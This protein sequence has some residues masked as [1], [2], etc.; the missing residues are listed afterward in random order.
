MSHSG[1]GSP[2]YEDDKRS[3]AELRTPEPEDVQATTSGAG[4]SRLRETGH[5]GYSDGHQQ[6]PYGYSAMAGTGEQVPQP[7]S[8]YRRRPSRPAIGDEYGDD[9][10]RQ[11]PAEA[12]SWEGREGAFYNEAEAP[13]RTDMQDERGQRYHSAAHHPQPYRQQMPGSAPSAQLRDDYDQAPYR[14]GTDAERSRYNERPNDRDAYSTP[15]MQHRDLAG[16][17]GSA[18]PQMGYPM[19]QGTN[20][21]PGGAPE[22]FSKVSDGRRYRLV[23]VQHPNR[24]RMC[25]FGDKDRRPLSPTLIVKLIITDE[26]TGQEV[27]P[28][29]VN[30]SLFLLATDLCHPDDLMLAPRNILVHHNALTLPFAAPNFASGAAS[31]ASTPAQPP[32]V[33]GEHVANPETESSYGAAVGRGG[34]SEIGDLSQ[35]SSQIPSIA[36]LDLPG[37]SR[38]TSD[39]LRDSPPAPSRPYSGSPAQGMAHSPMF[40]SAFAHMPAESYTRNLVGAAVASASVLKDES[41]KWCTFFVFQDI[42][43]RTEGVYRI[44]LM[45]VNLEVNGRVGTGVSEALAETYTEPFTVYSPRKFPGMLD[46]TPLSR[47]LASQGIKIPVRNDKKKQRRRADD[48]GEGGGLV[49]VYD[50]DHNDDDNDDE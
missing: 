47:K 34:R 33:S 26:A 46:P 27:S 35:N 1:N 13:Y 50:D 21:G 49:G 36:A 39:T 2:V 28:L 23:V 25:G 37:R 15:G 31:H 48:G 41:E 40:P 38:S 17:P 8:Y 43:V 20:R 30:T 12:G 6:D 4:P 7:P 5:P 19:R 29:D 32:Q 44:K 18:G 24:A 22:G 11:L 14:Y 42:S 45:F 10:Y 9:D 16:L 3:A